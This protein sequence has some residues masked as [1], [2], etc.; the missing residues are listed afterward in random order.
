MMG[1]H[2]SVFWACWG[3]TYVV[4]Y[5]IVAMLCTIFLVVTGLL[6]QTSPLV[7]FL[8]IWSFG[9][10]TI[11]FSFAVSTFI[12]NVRTG[13]PLASMF[14]SLMSLPFMA[15]VAAQGSED[16]LTHGELMWT[17][18]VSPLAFCLGMDVIWT[19]DGGFGGFEGMNFANI[20]IPGPLGVSVLES[21]VM[22][23]VDTAWLALLA[24][25]L[26]AVVPQEFG[27]QLPP[28]FLCLKP[29]WQQRYKMWFS[30]SDVGRLQQSHSLLR[31]TAD[32]TADAPHDD[33]AREPF[34]ETGSKTVVVQLDGVTKIFRKNWLRDSDDDTLAVDHVN[35]SLTTGEIFGLLGHNGAGK[36][37]LM[38]IMTGLHTPT[39]GR[40][41]ING[42]DCVEDMTAIRQGLGV[43]P[44]HDILYD[45]LTVFEHVRLFASIKGVAAS[46]IQTQAEEWLGKVGLME[47]LNAM[48][49]TLSGGQKRRL[50]C[51]LAMI[52]DPSV[53]ILDEPTTGL[54]P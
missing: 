49:N 47:K 31:A 43:C 24:L 3:L 29:W 6:T 1:L 51:A 20:H 11:P 33:C 38:G 34:G 44:Q 21:L 27:S 28:H 42:Y 35:L 10:S 7:V 40:A 18:L 46:Q 53:V 36:T 52:G 8:L 2:Y 5:G 4:V 39:S 25:Y 26:D 30:K 19:F 22:L 16:A 50:S 54:D 14:V 12:S 32:A 17:S 48:T 41:L 9:I 23:W 13:G 45:D 37:T 15:V